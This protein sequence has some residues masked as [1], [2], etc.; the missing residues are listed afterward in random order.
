MSKINL[1]ARHNLLYRKG[2]SHYKIDKNYSFNRIPLNCLKHSRFNS[3]DSIPQCNGYTQ[4][5]P[6]KKN[7]NNY[8]NNEFFPIKYT[9]CNY[10]RNKKSDLFYEK[11]DSLS[12]IK[13]NKTYNSIMKKMKVLENT[14][15]EVDKGMDFETQAENRRRRIYKKNCRKEE[16]KWAEN[17]FNQICMENKELAKN[18]YDPKLI[19]MA[20]I[21][22]DCENMKER[23]FK[24]LAD[25]KRPIGKFE[26]QRLLRPE[27][28]KMYCKSVVNNI[29]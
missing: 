26:I 27:F 22:N 21:Q 24:V 7:I 11:A 17:L 1:R 19:L 6:Y 12:P 3:G 15:D 9:E 16:L 14:I 20:G 2:I 8:R 18:V 23:R 28:S 29:R 5:Y 10:I 25:P 4:K 13:S